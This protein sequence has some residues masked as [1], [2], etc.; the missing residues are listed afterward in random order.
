M[1]WTAPKAA[2]FREAAAADEA[3]R[4]VL[5]LTAIAVFPVAGVATVLGL[6]G[7]GQF[8]LLSGASLSA[9]VYALVWRRPRDRVTPRRSRLSPLH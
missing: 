2:G 1:M 9:Y 8:L 3:A 7:S 5:G 4:L 6:L